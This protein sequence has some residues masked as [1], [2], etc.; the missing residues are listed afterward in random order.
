MSLSLVYFKMRALAEAPQMLMKSVGMNYEYQMSW[1]YY[2]DSWDIIKP[3]LPFKQLPVLII[4]GIHVVSQSIAI[5][6]YIE[7]KSGLILEDPV[8]QAK[9]DSIL[10]S[11]QELFAP[12]NPTVNFAVGKDF[13]AKRESMMSNLVSRFEDLQRALTSSRRKFFIDD[14]PRAAEFATYHHLDLSQKLD[15]GLIKKFSRLEQFMEDLSK[16][17]EVKRYLEN[18]P[19]LVGI[20]EKPQLI[21]DGKAHPTGVQKT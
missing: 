19:E 21:I 3:T 12:L 18:R 6:K 8:E 7:G 11:A 2:D 9:S 14:T 1:E 17:P 16:I 13:L 4:D 10:Q 15:E 20:G 5:M